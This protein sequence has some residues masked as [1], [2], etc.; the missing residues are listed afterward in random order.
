M[1]GSD[2]PHRELLELWLDIERG[3]AV[4]AFEERLKDI[5][6]GARGRHNDTAALRKA[7]YIKHHAQAVE[8]ELSS[9]AERSWDRA[10]KALPHCPDALRLAHS[11]LH[12]T[13]EEMR[14]RVASAV[15]RTLKR[16]HIERG[17][18][19]AYYLLRATIGDR[20]QREFRLRQ[21]QQQCSASTAVM[22][23]PSGLKRVRGW[24]VADTAL[25][26]QMRAWVLSGESS[27][28]TDAARG[29]VDQA[30][31]SGTVESKIRRLE[32]GY[33]KVYPDA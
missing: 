11:M 22:P 23:T 9:L 1:E 10:E 20:L 17:D 8:V 15:R 18:K 31:G 28:P 21:L 4:R 6:R 13:L 27:S 32:R 19:V 24:G 33:Y 5:R 25:I 14:G 3:K 16:N 12:R 26:N 7:G 30:K 2:N 29:L